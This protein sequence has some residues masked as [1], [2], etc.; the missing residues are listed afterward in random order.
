MELGPLFASLAE[1]IRSIPRSELLVAALMAMVAGWVGSAMVRR[2]IA[3]GGMLRAA[4]SVVLGLVLLTVM[5]Q[6]SRMD[7]RFDIAVPQL[8]MP[9][10]IVEGGETR[11]P[12]AQ[13]GH[14]WLRAEINGVPANF[15]VDTGATY[16]AISEDVAQRAGLTPRRG[17]IPIMLETANGTISAHMATVDRL[18][19]GNISAT[20]TD[21]VI[22]SNFGD[23][24]VIGMNVLARLKSWKVE[25]GVLVLVPKPADIAATPAI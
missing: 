20:G 5:L 13:N 17:G 15:L 9:E 22:A 19:F 8:G 16:T 12:M 23:T 7:P 14:F 4:S 18:S 1:V 6:L 3:F 10:Q 2:R 24:N 11:I 21:A 25:D